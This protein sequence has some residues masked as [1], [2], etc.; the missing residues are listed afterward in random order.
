MPWRPL[1]GARTCVVIVVRDT[2]A[3]SL[4][5]KVERRIGFSKRISPSKLFPIYFRNPSSPKAAIPCRPSCNASETAS[6]NFI[7]KVIG[8]TWSHLWDA[9]VIG[10]SSQ[11]VGCFWRISE[12][13]IKWNCRYIKRNNTGPLEEMLG[14]ILCPVLE[15]MSH[16]LGSVRKKI[17]RY[18]SWQNLRSR[19]NCSLVLIRPV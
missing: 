16:R 1:T 2:C 13:C 17:P 14:K 8:N 15:T 9:H 11:P 10:R 19:L 5:S 3:A 4:T 6:A 18:V 12:S 7:G